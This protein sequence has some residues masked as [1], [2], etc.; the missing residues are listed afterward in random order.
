MP[1]DNTKIRLQRVM[2]DAG[3]A[4]R[5]VCEQMIEDGRVQVNGQV[6]RRLPVF[7]DPAADEITVEGRRLAKPQRRIY[8]M[9]NK[10]AGV[11]VSTADE[12]EMGRTTIMDLVDHPSATRLFPVGRLDFDTTGMVILTNDGDLANRLTHARYRVPK[13]YQAVVKGIVDERALGDIRAKVR[14]LAERESGKSVEAPRIEFVKRDADRT[15]LELTLEDGPARQLRDAFSALGMP[16]KK[17]TRI[18][19]GA[20]E[21]RGLAGAS[22]K[23]LSRDEVGLLR[24][25]SESAKASKPA[26][27]TRARVVM[28]R[29]DPLPGAKRPADRQ[30]KGERR[31]PAARRAGPTHRGGR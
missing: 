22:W 11:I 14:A 15:L 19:I 26:G 1:A 3:I 16:V 9:V 6:V 10:P 13:R 7:V 29:R 4:A 12:P 5:R 30:R 28:G 20:L 31:P 2:A 17:L 21:L 25:T 24:K 18:A 23:E 27:R 8:L